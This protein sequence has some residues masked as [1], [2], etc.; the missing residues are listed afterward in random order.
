MATKLTKMGHLRSCPYVDDIAIGQSERGAGTKRPLA[1]RAGHFGRWRRQERP[2]PRPPPRQVRRGFGDP[3]AHFLARLP[4]RDH[5]LGR[6]LAHPKTDGRERE[7]RLVSR[8]PLA[9][10]R[11][12]SHRCL[13]LGDALGDG[14]PEPGLDLGAPSFELGDLE[15]GR[16]A[17]AAAG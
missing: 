10:Q 15:S 11:E 6:A 4:E 14:E 8:P 7:P 9:R 3:P 1:A 12:L 2:Q 17:V 16:G 5:L 13:E